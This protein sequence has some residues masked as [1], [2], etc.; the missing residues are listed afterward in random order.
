MADVDLSPAC[1]ANKAIVSRDEAKRLSLKRYFTGIPCPQ[2]HIDERY[3]SSF[4]C[5][6]CARQHRLRYYAESPEKHRERC[7]RYAERNPEKAIQ[8]SKEYRRNNLEKAKAASRKTARRHYE[9]NKEKVAEYN[10]N[11]AAENADKRRRYNREY[12]ARNAEKRRAYALENSDKI[13]V[14]KREYQRQKVD[15]DPNYRLLKNVRVRLYHAL[16][17]TAKSRKTLD[18]LGCTIEALR[19]HIEAQFQPGM[20]WDNWGRGLNGNK[21]WQVDHIRALS[22]F[23]LSKPEELQAACH[24]TNLQPLWAFENKSKGAR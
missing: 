15:A 16:K 5:V 13:R 20:S 8:R 3:C 12:A 24:F 2:G 22:T 11:W 1:E 21:E 19:V 14:Y 7:R 9:N 17:G 23:D 4:A 6:T 10:R 18:L